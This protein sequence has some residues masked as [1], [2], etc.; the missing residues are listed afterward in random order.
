M[1]EVWGKQRSRESNIKSREEKVGVMKEKLR[2][3]REKTGK[4]DVI[5]SNGREK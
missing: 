1:K 2:E 5:E 4:L 3:R